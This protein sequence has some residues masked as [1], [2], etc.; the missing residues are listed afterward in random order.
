MSDV[1]SF[2]KGVAQFGETVVGKGT[3]GQEVRRLPF[4]GPWIWEGVEIGNCRD[5]AEN[6]MGDVGSSSESYTF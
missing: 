5:A 2:T 6:I 4:L 1:M 3:G